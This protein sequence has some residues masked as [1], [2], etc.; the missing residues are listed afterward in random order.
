LAKIIV[1]APTREIAV[2]RMRFALEETV[3]AGMGSNQRYLLAIANDANVKAGWMH[4]G[5]L[6]QV[7]AEFQP[8]LS[9]QDLA[10]AT[11]LA[12][13]TTTAASGGGSAPGATV[14]QP[15]PWRQS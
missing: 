14:A 6:G 1:H 8:V 13:S 3:V 2:E 11:R 15:S 12:V 7:F 9:A 5:Y 10:T 4:T